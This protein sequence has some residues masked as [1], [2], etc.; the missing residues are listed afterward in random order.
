MQQK[1][2][3]QGPPNWEHTCSFFARSHC[4][5]ITNSA[6]SSYCANSEQWVQIFVLGV[7]FCVKAFFGWEFRKILPRYLGFSWISVSNTVTLSKIHQKGFGKRPDDVLKTCYWN[8]QKLS[9]VER[10][11]LPTL[12]W[13][14][15]FLT[16]DSFGLSRT[17]TFI[18]GCAIAFSKKSR[19]TRGSPLKKS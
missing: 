10:S 16:N 12:F 6:N 1:L 15:Y 14:I 7:K 18:L 8:L 4:S 13:P 11:C 19:L 3:Y 9:L 5:K 17:C 2:T